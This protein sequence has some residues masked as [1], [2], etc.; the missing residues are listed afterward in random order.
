[1]REISLQDADAVGGSWSILSYLISQGV[2]FAIGMAYR[3][4]IDYAGVAEA[5]GHYHNTVGA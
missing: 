2:S 3:G 4:E 5:Q 1:M